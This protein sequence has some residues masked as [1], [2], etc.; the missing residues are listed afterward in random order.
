MATRAHARIVS[1]N[2]NGDKLGGASVYVY[3]PGTTT[4]IVESLYLANAGGSPTSNPLTADGNGAASFYLDQPKRVD[5]RVVAG[6]VDVTIADVPVLPDAENIAV[7][8]G[9]PIGLL[10]SFTDNGQ[11]LYLVSTQDTNFG[12]VLYAYHTSASPAANDIPFDLSVYGRD[13]G[14]NEVEYTKLRTVIQDPAVGSMDAQ[15]STYVQKAGG[16]TEIT[17]VQ[18]EGLQVVTGYL[19]L[20]EMSLPSGVADAAI[21]YAVD[22]GS[23]KTSLRAIFGSGAAQTVVTQ[24]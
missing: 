5:L 23:G 19:R 21:L 16:L 7:L 18:P 4:P 3:Q 12:T 11:A 9:N 8:S 13:S 22:N 20:N 17:R 2:G 10:L 1:Q 14:A 15:V 6:G 24:P